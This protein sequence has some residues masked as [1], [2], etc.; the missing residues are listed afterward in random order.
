MS[1]TRYLI[2]GVISLVIHGVVLSFSPPEKPV[3][4][5]EQKSGKSI[6]ISIVSVARKQPEADV[7]NPLPPKEI[8]EK[9]AQKETIPEPE[10][11]EEIPTKKP[12][13]L[14][15]QP[16]PAK[17]VNQPEKIVE[18]KN[19]PQPDKKPRKV[20]VAK[21]KAKPKPTEAKQQKVIVAKKA[22]EKKAEIKK[23]PLP[24]KVVKK[25]EPKKVVQKKIEVARSEPV[26]EKAETKVDSKSNI[27]IVKKSDGKPLLVEKPTYKVKPIPPRYPRSA[28]RRGL[29]G[30]LLVEVWLSQS[31]EQ[32]KHVLL[33][34]SGHSQLDRAALKAIKNWKFSG[35]AQNGVAIAHRVRIPVHFKLD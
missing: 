25:E 13:L 9:T 29:E 3:I 28:R 11:P 33:R 26:S 2:C 27:D 31:G 15:K 22:D 24:K 8:K 34:S 5:M 20:V 16:V 30:K 12:Q 6:N 7:T 21:A 10:A 23:K 4:H 18:T 19:K 32:V 35:I 1:A 14:T 17:K